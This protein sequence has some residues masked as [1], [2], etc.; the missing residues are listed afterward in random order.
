MTCYSPMKVYVS[1]EVNP[2]TGKHG[3]TFSGQKALIEGSMQTLPCGQCIGCRID[4]SQGWAIRSHHEAVMARLE[5]KGSAFLTLTLADEHL[6]ANSVEVR[7]IQDFMR[8]LRREVGAS[9]KLRY[10]ACGEYGELLS[11]AHYHVLIFGYDFPDRELLFEKGA[12]KYYRSALVE[13]VWPYGHVTVGDVSFGSARYVASYVYKKV[14]GDKSEDYYTRVND[15]TGEIYAVS[16]EF[17]TQ[18]LKPGLGKLF[19]DKFKADIYPSDF[20]LIGNRRRKPPRYYDKQL[21]EEELKAVRRA[22]LKRVAEGNDEDW[23]KPRLAVREKCAM[24][25]I[26]RLRVEKSING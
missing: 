16:P 4:R 14:L 17:Q 22:R 9:V 13:K 12:F 25:R 19:F 10:L 8:A 3:R 5:G 11:R 24:L 1:A 26:E 18:S 6:G 23:T 21:S 2:A 15:E 20:V 7:A